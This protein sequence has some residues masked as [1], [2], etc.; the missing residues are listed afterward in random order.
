M[1]HHAGELGERRT[2]MEAPEV[3]EGAAHTLQRRR[4]VIAVL[5]LA[6][7][8]GPILFT[9]VALV[10]SLLRPDHSLV[11]LPIS[12][13]ATGPSGWVQDV[14]FVI[15]GVLML[16]YPIGLHLEIRQTRWGVVGPALLVLSGAGLVLAGVF[17]AVDASGNLSY[18]SLG[19]TVASFMAFLGTGGGFIVVSRRLAG[20]PRWRNL[21][22][23][24]FSSGIAIVVLVFAFGALAERPGTPLHPWI[25]LFQWVMVAVWITC[26]VVL[27]LR[28]LQVT[29]A[30]GATS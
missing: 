13:L 3:R 2:G 1:V 26:T 17:P 27:C 5:A 23:Y 11:G 16:A 19:H 28:L 20:D 29:R 22:T 12:A 8:V 9:V 18:D 10:H 21:A 14:N 6:G 25:G 24:A 7:I 15:S 30:T 4:S